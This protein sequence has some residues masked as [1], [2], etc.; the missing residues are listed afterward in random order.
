MQHVANSQNPNMLSTTNDF[1]STYGS[2]SKYFETRRTSKS[3]LPPPCFAGLFVPLQLPLAP[4]MVLAIGIEHA[5]DDGLG[6]A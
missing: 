2:V 4:M 6:P 3:H 1:Y 5:L